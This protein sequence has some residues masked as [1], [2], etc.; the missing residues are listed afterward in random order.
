MTYHD[1]RKKNIILSLHSLNV[2]LISYIT[3]AEIFAKKTDISTQNPKNTV[4]LTVF[5]P[6]HWN[7]TIPYLNTFYYF[8]RKLWKNPYLHSKF[9][10]SVSTWCRL[11]YNLSLILNSKRIYF[12]IRS[13]KKLAKSLRFLQF[14]PKTLQ[15]LHFFRKTF[16]LLQFFPI[17]WN[18]CTFFQQFFFRIFSRFQHSFIWIE[19]CFKKRKIIL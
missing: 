1:P 6:S 17:T 19:N 8:E 7:L 2:I 10:I 12:L 14:F 11:K 13:N 4:F 5:L 15:F 18:F 3:R 9:C 16:K